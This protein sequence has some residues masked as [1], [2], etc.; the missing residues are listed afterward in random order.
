MTLLLSWLIFWI[1]T[2][3]E[4]GAV[5][6][7]SGSEQDSYEWSN[8]PI[9]GGGYVTGLVVHPKEKDLAYIRTDVGGIYRWDEPNKKWKQ[10]VGFADRSQIN[11]YGVDSIAID[12]SDPDVLYAALGKYD[13]WTPSD[14][15]KSK[16][17]GET[18]T[19]THLQAD[20][21]DVP[22]Y[23][24]GPARTVERIAVD[25]NDG[26]VIYFGSRTK[27]LY[28]STSAAN[29][30]SW[31]SVASF[32]AV[33]D[34]SKSGITFIVFDPRT[35]SP[36]SKSQTLYVGVYN[37]GVYKSEDGGASWSL[38]PGSPSKPVRAVI[39]PNGKL[40]VTHG[41]GLA[42]LD[43][44]NWLNITPAADAGQIFGAITIDPGNPDIVMTARKVDG[45]GNPIYRSTDGG[46]HWNQVQYTRNIMTPWMPDW[47]W[48]S[49]TSSVVIDPFDS[50]KVWLT[51][52]Y[53]A[54]TTE[55]ITASPS[56]WTNYAQGLETTVNVSNLISPVSGP[57]VLHSGIADN[58]GFDHVSLT[59]F[60]ASTYFTG[61]GGINLLTTTGID[62]QETNP[63]FVVRVGTYGWNGDGRA[64]P[65]NGGYSSNAGQSYTAFGSLPYKGAQGGKVAVSATDGSNI[66]WSPQKGDVYYTIDKGITWVKSVG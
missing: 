10:L 12:P 18:W 7:A 60:P 16:D 26:N 3:L 20:G 31:T 34:T 6:Q 33:N 25:P 43:G 66:V 57:A 32:P 61:T 39:D 1:Q 41:T 17:R 47:H 35:G 21:K 48:S 22:M 62:V 53:Y 9:G 37:G 49:A 64:D 59:E 19:R 14:I 46:V 42:K 15:F 45:H 24:N 4:G 30:G 63:Q 65:G 8:V 11:L 23:A 28:R 54:W 58:G 40:Y 27:G 56:V 44:E 55:D 13:Y 51:D 29:S 5:A 50:K 52:W 36:G 2:G 38:L